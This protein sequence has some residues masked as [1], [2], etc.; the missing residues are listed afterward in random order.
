MK[1]FDWNEQKNE[2]LKKERGISFEKI[3][4]ALNQGNLLA[5]IQHADQNKYPHQK[6]MYVRIYE[7]VY[8]V[9]YVQT[10]EVIFFKTIYPSRKAKAKYNGGQNGQK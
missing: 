4:E 2:W 6:I 7:Y 3:V 5:D 9:P 10:D 8:A 1:Q